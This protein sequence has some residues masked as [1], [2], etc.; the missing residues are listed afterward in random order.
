M[1]SKS[2]DR[3][4]F[5]WHIISLKLLESTKTFTV[6]AKVVHYSQS[7]IGDLWT[8]LKTP[9]LRISFDQL[10]YIFLTHSDQTQYHARMEPLQSVLTTPW[11]C[12]LL[13][14]SSKNLKFDVTIQLGW[15]KCDNRLCF[16]YIV[17]FEW[18]VLWK[19]RRSQ[20]YF[21][22]KSASKGFQP[23]PMTH[24]C[25]CSSFACVCG[26]RERKS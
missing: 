5:L 17:Q 10:S 22:G 2:I 3:W 9:L 6:H 15:C 14:V 16:H 8:R 7:V 19:E 24:P 20:I 23:V 12:I 26:L 13:R 25:V 4:H 21:T 18:F 1:M 11:A